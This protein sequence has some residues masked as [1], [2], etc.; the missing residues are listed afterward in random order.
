MYAYFKHK[1]E[2]F[3]VDKDEDED[4]DKDKD[5]DEGFSCLAVVQSRGLAVVIAGETK[6]SHDWCSRAVL[7]SGGLAVLVLVKY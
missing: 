7:Q 6:Q 1:I 4:E 5:V 3:D 2:D